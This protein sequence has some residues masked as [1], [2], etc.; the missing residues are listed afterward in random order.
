MIQ[1]TV[2]TKIQPLLAALQVEHQKIITVAKKLQVQ[3]D[4]HLN[5]QQN[6]QQIIPKKQQR[7]RKF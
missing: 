6:L 5:Y 2:L 7:R 3:Q 1:V 4:P